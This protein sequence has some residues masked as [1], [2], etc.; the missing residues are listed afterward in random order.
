MQRFVDV[1]ITDLE[2]GIYVDNTDTLD[3]NL[4]DVMSAS[5]AYAG[6]FP[7]AE[8][9]GGTW[10]DGSVIREL[11]VFSAV[12]KCLETHSQKDIVVD[13]LLTHEKT[14]KPVD[15]SNYTAAEVLMRAGHI[16]RYYGVMDGLLRAQFAYPD[17]TFR[18]IVSPSEDLGDPLYPLVSSSQ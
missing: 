2:N 11:D 9:M 18:S 5:F 14:L 6:F 4:L 3:T 1:G 10:Y 17:I 12:N 15:A 16:I 8:S 13:V 7:P